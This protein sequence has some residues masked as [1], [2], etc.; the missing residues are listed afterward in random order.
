[1]KLFAAAKCIVA[2]L[3]LQQ[4]IGGETEETGGLRGLA[5]T[6]D[7]WVEGKVRSDEWME[8]DVSIV[9]NVSLLFSI[10]LCRIFFVN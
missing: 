8:Y 5:N 10:T 2:S 1:M 7:Y 3:W 6:V 9:C 4:V